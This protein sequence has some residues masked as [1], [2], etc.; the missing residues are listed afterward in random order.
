M[1]VEKENND[2]VEIVCFL[3]IFNIF[4][5]QFIYIFNITDN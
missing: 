1:K 5:N 4:I 2:T 3:F